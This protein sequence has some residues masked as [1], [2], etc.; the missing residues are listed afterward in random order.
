MGSCNKQQRSIKRKRRTFY[1]HVSTVEGYSRPMKDLI[2]SSDTTCNFE[3]AE[4]RER[5]LFLQ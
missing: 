5:K 4:K 3:G 2:Y 1:F